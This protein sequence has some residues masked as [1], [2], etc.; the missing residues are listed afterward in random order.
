VLDALEV[1]PAARARLGEAAA[2]RN[3]VAWRRVARELGLA[4]SAAALVGELPS[5]RGGAA[6]L[7]RVA[8]AAPTAGEA[9]A[10]LE[11]MLALVDAHA[12]GAEVL[13]DLGVQRDWGYYSGIVLEAYAPDVGSPIAMGG[14]YDG[15]AARFGRPRPAVGFAIS[16]DLLHRALAASAGGDAL[17]TGVVL[18]GG[19]DEDIA[20]AR[21]LRA[22]G[23]PVIALPAGDASAEGLAAAEGWRY[24][25]RRKG[26]GFTMLDRERGERVEAPTL[27]EAL[28]WG[29]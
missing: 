27:E 9:C 19:L 7:E 10:R 25:A 29:G 8:R 14:R 21:A 22:R 13:L 2:A 18:V 23:V 1:R 6:V 20:A 26:D 17:L 16:L 11:R 15:L 5:L 3:L 24:V 28:P 12:A 4:P